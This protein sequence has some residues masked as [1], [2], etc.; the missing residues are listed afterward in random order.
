MWLV[1]VVVC[2]FLLVV[3]S[4]GWYVCDLCAIICDVLLLGVIRLF[5]MCV[6]CVLVWVLLLLFELRCCLRVCWVDCLCVC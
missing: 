6:V 3:L 2:V 4:V 5:V 1:G